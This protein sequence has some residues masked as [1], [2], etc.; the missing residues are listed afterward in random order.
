MINQNRFAQYSNAEQLEALQ[1]AI[2]FISSSLRL[3]SFTLAPN[4]P[5]GVLPRVI[6]VSLD[7]PEKGNKLVIANLC[8]L[9]F[10]KM[11][12]EGR[13]INSWD[14]FSS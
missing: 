7:V 8:D 10:K 9:G 2:Q 6:A 13:K 1:K 5:A 11:R 4:T 14:S 12:R 3:E